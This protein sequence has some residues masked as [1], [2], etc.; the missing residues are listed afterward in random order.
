MQNRKN[1][2]GTL[3][4]VEEFVNIYAI[5]RS[6]EVR[7]I[8]GIELGEV[9]KDVAI[10]DVGCGIRNTLYSLYTKGYT[11]LHGFDTEKELVKVVKKTRSQSHLFIGNA[12]DIPLKSDY[13]DYC[14]CYDLLE[15]VKK[16]RPVLKEIN[17][18]L[19]PN[20]ILY[21]TIANG[22]SINDILFRRGGE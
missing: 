3:T 22:Y 15:H 14:K 21:I 2:I 7:G 11:K 8:M 13:F 1:K 12:K 5:K 16:P 20:G 17:R 19:K 10:L 6:K 9:P 4:N 18:I